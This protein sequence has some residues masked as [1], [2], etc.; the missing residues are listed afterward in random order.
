[1]IST[2]L[3]LFYFRAS[4]LAGFLRDFLPGMR[5]LIPFFSKASQHQTTSQ[6]RFASIPC[7]MERLSSRAEAPV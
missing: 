5:G 1:M 7:A 2:R 3:R 6:L 4:Y